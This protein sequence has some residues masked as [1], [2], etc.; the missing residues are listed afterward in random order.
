M[1]PDFELVW[2]NL[3]ANRDWREGERTMPNR[4]AVRQ[5]V[6]KGRTLQAG[7]RRMKP[8]LTALVVASALVGRQSTPSTCPVR[9]GPGQQHQVATDAA[10][11]APATTTMSQRRHG[12]SIRWPPMRSDPPGQQQRG[13]TDAA[14][15]PRRQCPAA[16]APC[17]AA[18]APCR[19]A[20]APCRAAWA[21]CPAARA[22]C[23]AG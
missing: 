20:R 21:P 10:R 19:A 4:A 1:L 3:R 13:A 23:P 7:P 6:G 17:R 22:P 16:Q 8:L 12:N 5:K 15:A 2:G 14:P 11:P 9:P 18:W